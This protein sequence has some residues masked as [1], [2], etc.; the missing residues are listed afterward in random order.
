MAPSTLE[1]RNEAWLDGHA[2]EWVAAGLISDQQA[3]SIRH[4]EHLDDRQPAAPP[5]L[6][7][8]AEVASY[9]GSVIA[10]AGGAAI[11]GPNWDE[12]GMVGQLG[13]AGLVAM[14]GFAVGTWLV[15]LAEAGTERLG[16]FLWVVGTGGVAMA[17]AVVMNEIDPRREAWF[18]IVIG[19]PLVAIGMALW[20]NLDR[21]LQLLTASGGVLTV[22]AGVADLADVSVW[23]TAPTL[24]LAA[25]VFGALAGFDRVRPRLVALAIAAAGVMI[26]S[27]VFAGESERLS[28][29]IAVL[30]AAMIVALALIERSWVLVAMGLFSFLIATMS[31]M[32]TVLHGMG[33]RLVAVLVGLAVVASVAIRAQ[34]MGGAGPAGRAS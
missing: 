20:R 3:E 2:R 24:W 16:S 11:I 8:V 12:L 6:T 28:A 25:A 31:L 22:G 26:G 7:T 18:A 13:L 33:A 29:I 32:Q 27:F 17:A 4:F 14:V 9:L 10:F 15:H 30:S 23:V 5:R 21:P 1:R 19:L 34:R